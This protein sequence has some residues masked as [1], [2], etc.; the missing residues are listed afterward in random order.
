MPYLALLAA[1]VADEVSRSLAG[2]YDLLVRV[3]LEFRLPPD[4]GITADFQRGLDGQLA[5][6]TAGC[7]R[8]QITVAGSV[9]ERVRQ[10]VAAVGGDRFRSAWSAEP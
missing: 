10:V 9:A 8:P 1:Q 6:Y 3:P 4:A 2:R 7:P 5:R